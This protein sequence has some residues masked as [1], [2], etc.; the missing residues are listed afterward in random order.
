MTPSCS[1]YA[2]I[3]PTGEIWEWRVVEVKDGIVHPISEPIGSLL[4]A[5]SI[6]EKYAQ[7]HKLKFYLHAFLHQ[8]SPRSKAFKAAILG[9][10]YTLPVSLP[11]KY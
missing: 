1:N 2:S 11:G 9:C 3:Q 8:E 6:G 5:Q 10:D 7:E 4:K